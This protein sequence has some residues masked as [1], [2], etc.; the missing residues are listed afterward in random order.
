MPSM[1]ARSGGWPRGD[2]GRAAA[3]GGGGGAGLAAA[4]AF[5]R[6]G[7]GSA[8]TG[9]GAVPL[10]PPA[11]LRTLAGEPGPAAAPPLPRALLGDAGTERRTWGEALAQGAAAAGAAPAAPL[12]PSFRGLLLLGVGLPVEGPAWLGESL[13]LRCLLPC[14]AGRPAPRHAAASPP[15]SA[16]SFPSP[17]PAR[18]WP[19]RWLPEGSSWSPPPPPSRGR[20]LCSSPG[21]RAAAAAAAAGAAAGGCPGR[22]SSHCR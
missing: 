22:L 5:L 9:E 15:A 19:L 21:E 20:L 13:R 1:V 12:L 10:L 6:G 2:P 16:A 3:A 8:A 11:T 7:G 17:L 4:L 14:P 18:P